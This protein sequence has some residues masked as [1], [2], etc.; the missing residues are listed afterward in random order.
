MKRLAIFDFDGTLADTSEGILYC[1]DHGAAQLGYVPAPRE[2]YEGVIGGHV[3]AGFRKVYG[4]DRALSERAMQIYRKLYQEK[5]MYLAHLYDG[6]ER[7]L[8]RL[9][10]AGI[11][12]ALATL[13]HE[14]FAEKMLQNLG[15]ADYFDCICAF[16]GSAG[17]DKKVLLHR[18]CR[19]LNIPEQ[20]SV[21]IGD[22]VFDAI[23]AEQAGMDFLAVT[24]GLGFRN[25]AQAQEQA[26]VGVLASADEIYPALICLCTEN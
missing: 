9:K 12:I 21:L 22:S 11:R 1:Y 10:D 14:R 13:K 23:G 7:T 3:D 17:C 4:M 8:R 5:G 20:D 18:V 19:T 15:V 16:D 2:Q 25:A 6:M 24:Y 26:N